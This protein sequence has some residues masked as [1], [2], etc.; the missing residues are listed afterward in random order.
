MLKRE[1]EELAGYE[2]SDHDYYKIIEP[3]Y[4]ATDLDKAAFVECIDKK[5]F[6][7]PTRRQMI[8]AMKKEAIHLAESCGHYT[9]YDSIDRL[10]ALAYEYAARFHHIDRNNINHVLYFNHEYEYRAIQRGCTYP[11]EL[12][13]GMGNT[14]WER[15]TLV[16]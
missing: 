7:L 13:I 15:I 5:R 9:D 10:E 8:N 6:A 2:V 11:C 14:V 3:M 1:F 12:V 4:M 16:K